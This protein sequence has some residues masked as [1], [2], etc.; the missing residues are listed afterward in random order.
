MNE[1]WWVRASRAQ[2]RA[3]AV[4]GPSGFAVWMAYALHADRAT[5]QGYPSLNTVAKFA[6]ISREQARRVRDRLKSAG[7]LRVRPMY[8]GPGASPKP[9]RG[10]HPNSPSLVTVVGLVGDSDPDN[11]VLSPLPTGV[12]ETRTNTPP[13]R[14]SAWRNAK[15]ALADLRLAASELGLAPP[16]LCPVD[17][18]WSVIED[19]VAPVVLAR[20]VELAR[21]R[22]RA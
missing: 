21:G 9:A 15:S 19:E 13:D 1:E 6:A 16:E 10:R 20:A 2:M 4:A 8:R 12:A 5:G 11:V 18:S 3:C 14:R 7:L 22:D 17:I